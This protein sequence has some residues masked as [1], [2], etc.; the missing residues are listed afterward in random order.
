MRIPPFLVTLTSRRY[1]IL[2][3]VVFEPSIITIGGNFDDQAHHS[4]SV[5]GNLPS[6]PGS[7]GADVMI[8]KYLRIKILKNK[9]AFFA[10]TTAM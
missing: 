5:A 9:L 10:L 7:P 1:D 3:T 6:S 8:L 4:N 2:N